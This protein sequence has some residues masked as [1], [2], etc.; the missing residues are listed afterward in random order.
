MTKF[1]RRIRYHLLE[2]NK[3]GK[4]FKYA[5]GEIFLVV[6]GILIALQINNWNENRKVLQDIEETKIALKKEL[7]KNIE[8]T[9]YFV[10]N[11]YLLS[12]VLQEIKT[13]EELKKLENIKS[14]YGEFGLFDTFVY[15]MTSDN[16]NEF[17]SLEKSLSIKD[18]EILELAKELKKAMKER[19]IWESKATELSLQ[20]FKEFSDELPWFYN[21]DSL[22]DSLRKD[23]IKNNPFF[24]SKAIHYINFQ[25]NENVF[26]ASEIRNEA[27]MLLWRLENKEHKD[28]DLSGF[29][30]KRGLRSFNSNDCNTNEG[31]KPEY[32]GFRNLFLIYNHST[33]KV[34]LQNRDEKMQISQ[35]IT[36]EPNQ[37][38]NVR[39]LDKEYIQQS[40]N[41]ERIYTPVRNGFLIIEE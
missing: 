1:F 17:I 30:N 11:G 20:R 38:E 33:N 22:S 15:E 16:L 25:L 32:L 5:I 12:D 13:N 40:D 14:F 2:K 19:I 27:L 39:F 4:Y 31:I 8:I 28:L 34:V 35:E 9:S 10:S 24:K 7:E 23:Y 26:Y 37:Y 3:T 18:Y 29:L 41:C 21:K 36:L 6:I